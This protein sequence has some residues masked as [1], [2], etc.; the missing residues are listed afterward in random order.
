MILRVWKDLKGILRI[1]QVDI[2]LIIC[3]NIRRDLHAH[4][5]LGFELP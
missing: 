4:P 1:K 5:E 3:E 2:L